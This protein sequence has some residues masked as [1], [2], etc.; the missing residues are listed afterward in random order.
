MTRPI[1]ILGLALVLVARPAAAQ[2]VS[3]TPIDPTRWDA[4]VTLGWLGGDKSDIA[5]PWNNWY[6]TFATS[7]DVG[8]YWTPHLKT[9][10]G[11]TLTT[12]GAVYS[13]RQVVLPGRPAPVFFTREH[14]F[15]LRALYLSASYQA[16]EN[17]W[18]HPFVT[19]GVQL[20]WERERFE[21]WPPT[22]EL[23]PRLPPGDTPGTTFDVRP[24]LAGGAKLYVHENGFIRTDLSTAFDRHGAT[25]VSWRIGAGI[26][27]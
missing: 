25:R 16:F 22:R 7:V 11:T 4:S 8:R 12:S 6:D 14:R 1:A 24:F 2:T 5:E 26:D 20:G 3:L 9:E 13:Q 19:A 21:N 15:S 27:F 10:V 17:A 23:A 18:A